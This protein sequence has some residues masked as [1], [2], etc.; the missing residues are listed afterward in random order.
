[1]R[2]GDWHEDQ[3]YCRDRSVRSA[4][5]RTRWLLGWRWWNC[6]KR[7]IQ[8]TGPEDH[9]ARHA[10]RSGP[11]RL[12]P[13]SVKD[14]NG[15][16]VGYEPDIAAA[17]AKSLGVKL[18]LVA[19]DGTARLSVM[20]SGRADVN[21]S[22]YTATDERAQKVGF[23]IP[24]KAQGAAVLFRK[25]K[26][27]SSLQGLEGKTVAVARGSTNDTIVTNDF[28]KAKPV[29]FDNIADALQALKSGKTDAVM[30]E[31]TTVAKDAKANPGL[32][33]LKTAPISP[34]LISMGVLP[35]QQIWKNYLDNFIRNMIASGQDQKLYK[36]W[37]NADLP[38]IITNQ[39]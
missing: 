25:S 1:M 9:Q 38:S 5:A 32:A 14:T 36:K 16:I 20:Q 13:S 34:D 35:N 8:L 29:R 37:F 18:Q 33:V 12:P 30:E 22:S 23:T 26:P 19:I 17:L 11:A 21:I 28:P 39:P 2:I 15:K 10:S 7:F 31:S 3:T 24:Y 27:I 4:A 6:R